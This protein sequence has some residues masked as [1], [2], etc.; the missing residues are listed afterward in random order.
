MT[1]LEKR[2]GGWIVRYREGGVKKS[3]KVYPTKTSAKR[4]MQ[5]IA[6]RLADKGE[7]IHRSEP[8]PN[9][10]TVAELMQ[11]QLD[12]GDIARQ[13]R[14]HANA[15]LKD[16]L[17]T[18][19]I[20][21]V[22]PVDVERAFVRFAKTVG[23]ATV[24]RR[25]AALSAG[26]KRAA[27]LGFFAGD[28][29][30]RGTEAKD[31]REAAKVRLHTD[32]ATLRKLLE[33]CDAEYVG[34]PAL[35]GLAGLRKGEI[36]A[37]TA[38]DVDLDAGTISVGRSYSRGVTKGKRRDLVSIHPELLPI[39]RAACARAPS[40]PLFPT[41]TGLQVGRGDHTYDYV[42]AEAREAAGIDENVTLHGLRHTF[43]T[44]LDEAGVSLP[45]LQSHMRHASLQMTA[46]YVHAERLSRQGAEVALIRLTPDGVEAISRKKGEG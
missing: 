19:P 17:A 6:V 43:A 26:Y 42:L 21:L 20:H 37:L 3:S 15:W 10:W 39:L 27:K 1:W 8:N 34:V 11:W 18:A 7:G 40:G 33:E 22:T 2:K 41:F 38:A 29:P 25:R 5:S 12:E 31:E 45:S 28:N 14:S 16:E 4:A 46:R 36:A 35:A 30:A 44:M 24:N 13:S 23:P 9:G 32:A